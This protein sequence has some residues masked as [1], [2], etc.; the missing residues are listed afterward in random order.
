[1]R[2]IIELPEDQ[3]EALAD[4]CRS[5]GISRAEAIRQAIAHYTRGRRSKAVAAAFGLWRTR[6]IDGLAYERQRRDE[7]A[8]QRAG[9]RRRSQ[10]RR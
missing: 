8:G 5:E 3:R 4:L 1:M 6:P 10:R 7:W 9:A 2:T